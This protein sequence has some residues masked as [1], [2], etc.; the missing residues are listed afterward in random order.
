ML[1]APSHVSDDSISG[2]RVRF[3][4]A[5]PRSRR[6][7]LSQLTPL[8]FYYYT[9]H[10]HE[11]E[12]SAL[13][14]ALPYRGRDYGAVFSRWEVYLVSLAETYLAVYAVKGGHAFQQP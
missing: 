1:H 3:Q 2:P 11:E 9:K 7:D 10:Y 14:E 13:H 6:Q 5:K 12:H 4:G 8:H